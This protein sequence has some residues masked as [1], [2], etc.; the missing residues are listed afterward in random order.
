MRDLN[1]VID[2]LKEVIP[3]SQ[4]ELIAGLNRVGY[5]YKNNSLGVGMRNCWFDCA[6]VLSRYTSEPT[7][8]WHFQV[9]D[10]YND[11]KRVTN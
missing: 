6:E 11:V 10:I 3:T 4:R 9:N 5:N 7:E 2:Q 8:D 1:V